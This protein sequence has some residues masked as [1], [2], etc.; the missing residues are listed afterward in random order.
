MASSSSE[1]WKGFDVEMDTVPAPLRAR[2]GQNATMG[3][4]EVLGLSHEKAREGVISACTERFDRRLVEETSALRL[5][6]AHLEDHLRQDIAAGRVEL[7]KW[8]FLF[9]VGQVLAIGG[10]MGVMLRLAR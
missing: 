3:L 7:I 5:Q 4:L 1:V 9:W 2:L 8:C 10:M 6:M